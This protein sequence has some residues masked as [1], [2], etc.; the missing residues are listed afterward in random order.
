MGDSAA[1]LYERGACRD[2]SARIPP[3][4]PSSRCPDC[5]ETFQVYI[6]SLW[7]LDEVITE[8]SVNERHG[9]CCYCGGSSL[10]QFCASCRQTSELDHWHREMYRRGTAPATPENP[11]RLVWDSRETGLSA[12]LVPSFDIMADRF[13]SKVRSLR[14]KSSRGGPWGREC[15]SD[16]AAYLRIAHH[17]RGRQVR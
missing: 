6:E 7:G 14:F 3:L 1:S 2:C 15:L 11:Y 5:E 17:I 9:L 8:R 16:A 10:F 4:G 12:Y 13:Q